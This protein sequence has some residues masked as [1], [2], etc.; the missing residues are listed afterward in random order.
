MGDF[1]KLGLKANV[2]LALNSLGFKE[3]LEVQDA[4]I[5]LETQGHNLVF[6]SKTGSGKTLA[7]TVGFL[8]KIN[9][10]Q[11]IQM[12]IVVPTRELCKQVGEEVKK[13]CNSLNIN[14]GVFYGGRDLNLDHRTTSKKNQIIV[15]TPGRLIQHVNE[16]NIKIGDVRYIV[17]DESDQMFDDGFYD[18]C[19]YLKKRAS[20][21]AQIILASATITPKVKMFLEREV[22]DYKSL[23]IGVDIPDNI[24]QEKIVCS[25]KEKNNLLL[26]FIKAKK[27]KK[28][29]VFCNTRQKTQD[30]MNFLNE[31]KINARAINGELEQKEREECI[32]G[33]KANKISVL[34]AT[35]VAARGLHIE[36]IDAI[37]NYDVHRI[38]RSG[39]N[40]SIGYAMTLVC[41][42]DIDRFKILSYEFDLDVKDINKKDYS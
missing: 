31:N 39:R 29:M 23:K 4:V 17:Y 42:Q 36:N 14:V 18:D 35:D 37:I 32:T 41:K 16:K 15:S 6:T 21:D 38:G 1:N 9:T 30:L 25:M 19:V 20:K 26:N 5:P 27:L 8:G 22:Q 3:S 34:T 24:V 28:V 40:N 33:F 10:K 11:A 13:I 12:L 2:I 7:Y